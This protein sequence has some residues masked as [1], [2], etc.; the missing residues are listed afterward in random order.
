MSGPER[1]EVEWIDSESDGSWMPLEQA[2][3]EAQDEALHR[4]CGY[5]L[6]DTDDY[7]LLGLNYRDAAENVKPMVADTI[8]IPRVV[9]RAVHPL[10]RWTPKAGE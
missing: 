7:V 8:R 1:V 2:L 5:L 9:V 10:R 3:Y 6:A 4:S